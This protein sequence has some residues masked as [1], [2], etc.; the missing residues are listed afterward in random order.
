MKEQKPRQ[1]SCLGCKINVHR[2]CMEAVDSVCV[3]VRQSMTEYETDICPTKGLSAQGYKCSDCNCQIG[4]DSMFA[5]ARICDYRGL[6]GCPDCNRLE[7]SMIP[8]RVIHNWDFR[9]RPVSRQANQVLKVMFTR[10]VINLA[11]EN[12]LLFK[13][14][15]EMGEIRQS[16]VELRS[17]H[18]FL[19]RCRIANASEELMTPLPNRQHL[20]ETTHMYSLNDL[21][22]IK[23]GQ[24]LPE[25]QKAHDR[26]EQHIR[27]ECELCQAKG[28]ICEI[29]KDRSIIYP[30]DQGI[31]ECA[32]CKA[33][34]HASCLEAAD[35]CPKCVR[36]EMYRS[37]ANSAG[38]KE[39]VATAAAT[40]E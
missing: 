30:F 25:L 4:I 9:L 10:P 19:V 37:R 27:Q 32:E 8:A 3:A 28:F 34:F 26:W 5:E 33:V 7:Q 31:T 35:R 24:L 20:C 2:K 11:K 16:R 39:A 29:C 12:A 23:Q 38:S 22:D 40:A 13:H 15:E 18:K 21:Y 1:F 36:I 17:M 14:V 6:Y